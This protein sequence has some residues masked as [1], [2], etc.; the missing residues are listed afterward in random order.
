MLIRRCN[1]NN[2]VPETIETGRI[3]DTLSFA[4]VGRLYLQ[5]GSA[6]FRYDPANPGI[7]T[8]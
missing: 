2:C 6:H 3:Y 8:T 4:A 1:V 7:N 5:S